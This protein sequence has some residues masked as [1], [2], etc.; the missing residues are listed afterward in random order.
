MADLIARLTNPEFRAG[1]FLMPWGMIISVLG[2]LVAWVIVT[3][4]EQTGLTRQIWN[5]P[6][7]F[8]ALAVLSGCL[9]GLLLAP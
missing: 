6:L 4:L 1:D 5:L 7:F 8:V 3:I 9:L 2:F